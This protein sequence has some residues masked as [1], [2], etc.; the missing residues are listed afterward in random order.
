LA[1]RK[2]LLLEKKRVAQTANAMVALKA[3]LMVVR[4]AA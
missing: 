3:A 2:D 1:V 4:T